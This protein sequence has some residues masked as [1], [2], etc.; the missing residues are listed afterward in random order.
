[1]ASLCSQLIKEE[2][3]LKILYIRPNNLGQTYCELSFH[4]IMSRM[5]EKSP[6]IL[7]SSLQNF[8][9]PIHTKIIF[10]RSIQKIVYF[11]FQ[12]KRFIIMV[13]CKASLNNQ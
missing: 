7:P 1:M 10:H 11:F 6:H 4:H 13:A 2:I 5:K 3:N 12:N 8:A 9:T